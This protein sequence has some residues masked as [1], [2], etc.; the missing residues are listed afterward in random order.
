MFFQTKVI[1][2]V[3]RM[4]HTSFRSAAKNLVANVALLQSYGIALESIQRNVIR[5]PSVYVRNV[6]LFKD[7]LIRVEEKWGIPQ[8]SRMFLYGASLLGC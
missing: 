2:T 3:C 1:A 7:I 4:Y 8:D 6:E 5:Q